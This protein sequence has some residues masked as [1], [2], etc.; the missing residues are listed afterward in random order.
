MITSNGVE[1]LQK[2]AP[3]SFIKYWLSIIWLLLVIVNFKLASYA[4]EAPSLDIDITHASLESLLNTQVESVS[5]SSER[6]WSAPAA[7]YRLTNDQIRRSGANSI[8]EAIRLIPGVNV[9]RIDSNK[10]SVSIRGFNSRSANKLLVLIDGRS[11]YDPLFSGV[12]WESKDVMLEDVDYIEVIRGPGGTLW[13]FNAVNGVI[14]IVT[15]PVSET[16]GGLISAGGGNEV[17]QVGA[18]RYGVK[19]GED[20]HFRAYGKYRNLDSG[21]RADD[22]HDESEFGQAGFRFDNA[23]GADDSLTLQGDYYDGNFGATQGLPQSDETVSGA[24]LLFKWN[25]EISNDQEVKFLTYYDHTELDL[26]SFSE[27]RDK[28][29]SDIQYQF[30]PFSKHRVVAGVNY[31]YTTDDIGNSEQLI[32]DPTSRTDHIAGLFLEDRIEI[33]PEKFFATLGSKVDYNSYTGYEVQPTIRAS[34]V[35]DESDSVW[36]SIAR[37]VRTPSRLEDDFYI[38]APDGTVLAGSGKQRSEDLLAYEVGFRSA[39]SDDVSLEIASFYNHYNDLISVEAVTIGNK[40]GGNTY[41]AEALLR[42]QALVKGRIEASY[43]YI[44]M[45]LTLDAD[46]L[47]SYESRVSD[48]EKSNPEHMLGVRAQY[49]LGQEWLFDV[50]LRYVDSLSALDVSSYLELDARLAYSLSDQLELSLIGQNLLDNHHFE[51]GGLEAT[52]AQRG[53]LGKAEL[54]F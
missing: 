49:D 38:S 35:I 48:L 34:W 8:P 21:Y 30:A 31:Q 1:F 43:S 7:V 5:K 33:I 12:L 50:M 27:L 51:Q 42:W 32:L 26:G 10:W 11:I 16:Q 23:Q 6:L 15:K 47:D 41:G 29:S 46:S 52:A 54:H 22:A 25:H 9:A 19:I 28:F 36:M 53:V 13:G 2:Q 14:N 39:L 45:D 4:Q 40:S 44:K 17:R 18:A 3:C 24:N 37:A 20:S